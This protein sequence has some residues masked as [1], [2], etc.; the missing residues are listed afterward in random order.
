[1][2]DFAAGSPGRLGHARFFYNKD[3]PRKLRTRQN[4]EEVALPQGGVRILE[5]SQGA[6]YV[7]TNLS[8]NTLSVCL[9]QF[10]AL[11]VSL[12]LKDSK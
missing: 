6:K 5:T 7:T 10:N 3:Q 2:G 11:D 9:F 4:R 12:H 8:E 1:M